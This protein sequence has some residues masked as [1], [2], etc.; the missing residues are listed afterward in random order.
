MRALHILGALAFGVVGCS[1]IN[2][3]DDVAPGNDASATGGTGT[4]SGGTGGTGAAAGSA[5]SGGGAGGSDAAAG[6]GAA[7]GG[8]S[9]GTT[10]QPGAIVLGARVANTGPPQKEVLVALSPHD[11]SELVREDVPQ[12]VTGLAHEGVPGRDF[13]YVLRRTEAPPSQKTELSIRRLNRSTTPATWDVLDTLEVPPVFDE[14][15]IA[16]LNRRLVYLANVQ[17]D[18][19]VST[20]LVAIDTSDETNLVLLPP[21]IV[22][23]EFRGLIGHPSTTQAG[24]IL[25]L[26]R[27]QGAGQVSI[28]V[29]KAAVPTTGAPQ[30]VE[31]NPTNVGGFLFP[32]TSPAWGANNVEN[33][34]VI[35]LPPVV[36]D[37]GVG[38][39]QLRQFNSSN[40]APTSTQPFDVGGGNFRQLA[41]DSCR[42]L[43][44]TVLLNQDNSIRV[45]PVSSGT[46][47][48][49]SLNESAQ[50]VFYE[51]YTQT[52]LAPFQGTNSQIRA[53]SVGGTGQAPTL[54]AKSL[55]A[56]ADLIPSG[57]MA[58]E[59]PLNAQY[60]PVCN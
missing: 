58:V 39:A 17:G 57:P 21:L 6:G 38:S 2:A 18:A 52:A 43:A 16:V 22:S 37:A 40:H 46:E 27:F 54:T 12:A 59:A 28:G 4:T 29:Q 44:I 7:G 45:V 42:K 1:V 14:K 9:G 19:G 53:F 15:G 5:G 36:T 3:F 35:V 11:G 32:S 56:P 8:G 26:I 50:R 33:F 20:A 41:F 55:N 25:S 24:G 60:K 23:D 47:A 51:P 13:W 30:M 31:N 49:L 34:D 10:A 48:K